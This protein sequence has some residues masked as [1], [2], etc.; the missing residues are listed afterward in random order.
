[1]GN[2]EDKPPQHEAV[3]FKGILSEKRAF[4][5]FRTVL[6]T[7]LYS[8]LVAMEV[9]VG[10]EIGDEVCLLAFP[11]SC[12]YPAVLT[13]TLPFYVTNTLFTITPPTH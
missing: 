11:L 13:P 6:H 4:G 10:G 12:T 1:M 9:P 2:R 8:Q 3:Y 5:D 7:G